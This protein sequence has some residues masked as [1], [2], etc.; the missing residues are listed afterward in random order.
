MFDISTYR[1]HPNKSLLDH[2]Q[3]VL[4]GVQLRTNSKVAEIAA[5]FHDVGKL[6]PNFQK[7]LDGENEKEYSNRL[8]HF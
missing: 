5:I 4:E 2:T 1:S 3:G 6:N 7:K 8:F